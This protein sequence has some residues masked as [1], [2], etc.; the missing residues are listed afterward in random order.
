MR[1]ALKFYQMYRSKIGKKLK[2]RLNSSFWS[3]PDAFGSWENDEISPFE[4]IRILDP[5]PDGELVKLAIKNLQREYPALKGIGV[6]RAWEGLIDTSPDLVPVIS[7]VE[8]LPVYVIAAGFSGHGF[9][10]GPGAGRLVSDIVLNETPMTDISPYTLSR[11]LDG[12][13]IRRPEMM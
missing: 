9:A 7:R 12:S 4:K 5:A 10:I 13:A 2:H 8:Q 6:E 3:G 11:F 1:Y